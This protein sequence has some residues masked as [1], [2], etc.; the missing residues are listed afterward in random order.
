MRFKDRTH[1]AEELTKS[2]SKFK[3]QPV[4][5]F[6]LPRGGVPLGKR[7][8]EKLN[9][10]L[11]LLIPRKI[12]H[13]TNPEYAIASVTETSDVIESPE[14][15]NVDQTWFKQEVEKQ[16]TEAKRRREAYLTKR[17]PIDTKNKTAII[18]DD[19]IA[20][21]LTM[22]AAINEAKQR[23]PSKI[24]LAVPIAPKSTIEDLS[25]MVDEIIV[26]ESPLL[27]LGSIGAYYDD[28]SQ[29]EDKEVVTFMEN[30]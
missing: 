9:A 19:G 8:A 16:R 3:E 22:K 29:V 21:G 25:T 15:K 11:D 20:T 4:V 14:V 18:V 7:V 13:P 17:S 26:L 1:A 30:T 24:I 12:G 23:E 10:P 28:F 27:F 2:L 5:I 6:A